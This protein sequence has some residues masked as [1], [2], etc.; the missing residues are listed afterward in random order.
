MFILVPLIAIGLFAGSCYLCNRYIRPSQNDYDVLSAAMSISLFAVSLLI[1]E[2]SSAPYHI[3]ER[4]CNASSSLKN[5][6]DSRYHEYLLKDENMEIIAIVLYLDDI[7]HALTEA[8]LNDNYANILQEKRLT[9]KSLIDAV[10]ERAKRPSSI[11][12][13]HTSGRP[14]IYSDTD[15]KNVK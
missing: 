3:I 8:W 14:S 11:H 5:D 1:S 4:L 10:K 12:T 15:D 7:L 13:D 9:M 2:L 6:T